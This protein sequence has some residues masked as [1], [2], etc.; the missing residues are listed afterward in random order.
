MNTLKSAAFW[1]ILAAF[2]LLLLVAHVP[3]Q[4]QAGKNDKPQ[5]ILIGSWTESSFAEVPA[6]HNTATRKPRAR[7]VGAASSNAAES[8]FNLTPNA[9]EKELFDLINAERRRMNLQQL[10]WDAEMLYLAREHSASMAQNR[11]FS[12]QGLNGGMVDQRARAAG[13]SDWQGIGENI[14]S[15]LNAADPVAVAIKCWLN[16]AAHRQNLLSADWSRSGIG[17]AVSP[18]GKYYFTQVF[19]D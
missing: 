2:F 18:E 5:A 11:F 19:R 6:S 16:S 14:T 8:A 3:A 13:I 17:V 1:Q 15:S 10:E 7:F 9:L 4:S 12:H